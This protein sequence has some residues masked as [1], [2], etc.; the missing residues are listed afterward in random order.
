[1]K[2]V[3]LFIFIVFVLGACAE[4]RAPSESRSRDSQNGV[5]DP[6][7]GT[8]TE[9]WEFQEE[10]EGKVTYVDTVNIAKVN[11][12]YTITCINDTSY[13]Y[14]QI[15]FEKEQLHFRMKNLESSTENDPFYVFYRL[16]LSNRA[17][18]LNGEITNS[19][20]K[21]TKVNFIKISPR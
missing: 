19:V 15:S 14:D 4:M 1:M 13:V 9:H 2:Q 21:T 7:V 6:L 5:D 17:D 3:F 18:R 11:Q 10:D 16:K 20:Q 8:W 12:Q